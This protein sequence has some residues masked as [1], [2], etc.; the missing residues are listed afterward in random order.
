MDIKQ[1]IP[2]KSF[3]IAVHIVRVDCGIGKY[4]VLKRKSA[5]LPNTWQMVTGRI[6]KGEKAW[7]AAL[8]EIRE[9]TGL[10]PDRLYS[11]NEVEVF[12][13]IDDDCMC[14]APVFVAFLDSD[15]EPKLSAEHSKF[16]WITAAEADQY[17][18]FDQQRRIIR[19]IED[20]FVSTEPNEFLKIDMEKVD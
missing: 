7:E 18:L 8:R 4:L 9:E 15:Q 16:R 13:E 1:E 11:A 2:I 5:Y 20:N 19:R 10:A 12:Y 6:E 3:A 14:L 17:L